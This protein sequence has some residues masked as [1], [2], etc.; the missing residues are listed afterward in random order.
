LNQLDKLVYD[1]L[2]LLIA[3]KRDH[4]FLLEEI[5][6]YREI[7]EP[8]PLA[9]RKRA[10]GGLSPKNWTA[11]NALERVNERLSELDEDIKEI[12]KNM[13]EY[14]SD[15]MGGGEPRGRRR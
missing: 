15:E 4:T 8:Y 10:T 9:K 11:Y 14:K 12:T 13:Y 2:N 5:Y 7:I 6:S 1:C 3:I